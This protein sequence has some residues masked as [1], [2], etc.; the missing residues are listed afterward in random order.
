MRGLESLQKPVTVTRQVPIE[1]P[2]ETGTDELLRKL[3]EKENAEY[4]RRA[5]NASQES[6][7]QCK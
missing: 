2:A 1:T 5:K 6:K 3:D 4:N 7:A